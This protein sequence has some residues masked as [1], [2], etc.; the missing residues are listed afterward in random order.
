MRRRRWGRVVFISWDGA[1]RGAKGPLDYALGKAARDALAERLARL[2]EPAG[3]RI[4]TVAPGAIP[5]L[6]DRQCRELVRHGPAWAGRSRS[7]PQDAA[8]CVAWLC[9]DEAAHVSG[10]HVRVYGPRPG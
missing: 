3:V 6:S 7:G 4:N 2:E 8:E 1:S 9:T 5:Y 10:S